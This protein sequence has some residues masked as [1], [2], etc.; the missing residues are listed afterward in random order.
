MIDDRGG[1]AGR[2]VPVFVV[3]FAISAM[4]FGGLLFAERDHLPDV[5]VTAPAS[6][7]RLSGTAQVAASY[8]VD[9]GQLHS[10]A[11]FAGGAEVES[12]S[13][14]RRS[15]TYTFSLDTTD[16]PNGSLDLRVEACGADDHSGH[17]SS[18]SVT[19]T[20]DNTP[21]ACEDDTDCD[22]NDEWTADRCVSP[23]TAA[24]SCTHKRAECMSD[25]DC[26]DNNALTLDACDATDA[27]DVKCVHT[28]IACN[29][30]SDCN[31]NDSRTLDTCIGGGTDAAECEHTSVECFSDGECD[32]KN[33]LTTDVCMSAGTAA[34]ACEHTECVVA[35]G[36]VSDC[37]DGNDLTLDTCNNPGACNASCGHI[38]VAC[39]TPA[40][41]DDGNDLT[42]DACAGAGTAAAACMHTAI[43]CNTSEDCA[44]LDEKTVDACVNGGTTSAACTHTMVVCNSAADCD[45]ED[46][47]TT[48][49][50]ANAGTAAA[51]CRHAACAVACHEDTDCDDGDAATEDVCVDNGTCNSECEHHETVCAKAADC[52]DGDDTT[53]D[54]CKNPGTPDAICEHAACIIACSAD[55]DCDDDNSITTDICEAEGTCKAA[56]S[57]SACSVECEDD[58]DCDDGDTGTVDTCLNPGTCGAICQNAITQEAELFIEIIDPA[59]GTLTNNGSMYITGM[60]ASGATVKVNG[61]DAAADDSGMFSAPVTLEEGKNAITAVAALGGRTERTAI[62]VTLDTGAPVLLTTE[63]RADSNFSVAPRVI[64]AR[65]E[66]NSGGAGL[67]V[68]SIEASVNGDTI[69]ARSPGTGSFEFPAEFEPG[70]NVIV[71]TAEDNAGNAMPP[72]TMI[73]T[74]NPPAAVDDSTL[75]MQ[76]EV[77]TVATQSEAP[78]LAAA[79]PGRW[80]EIVADQQPNA[81]EELTSEET[82]MTELLGSVL[83]SYIPPSVQIVTPGAGALA[84]GSFGV[85]VR[86]ISSNVRIGRLT[87][88]IDGAA[89]ASLELDTPSRIGG[90]TI[91]LDTLLLADG[92]HS[93]RVAAETLAYPDIPAKTGR[94]LSVGILVDNKPPE[95]EILSVDSD[96]ETDEEGVVLTA[97]FADAGAGIDTESTFVSID[98]GEPLPAEV[99][100]AAGK[101]R[102][103]RTPLSEGPH[104]FEVCA[105]DRA[106]HPCSRV[107]TTYLCRRH[108]HCKKNCPPPEPDICRSALIAQ[109][110]AV[111]DAINALDESEF[112]PNPHF[113]GELNRKKLV[114]P[115]QDALDRLKGIDFRKKDW[116]KDREGG[117]LMKVTRDI[118]EA[119]QHSDGW[120]GGRKMD[121][122]LIG[123]AGQAVVYPLLTEALAHA[124]RGG[125]CELALA[126]ESLELKKGESAQF[127]VTGTFADDT[128]L[129]LT[130]VATYTLSNAAVGSISATGVFTGL[131]SGTSTLKADKFLI[132]SNEALITVMGKPKILSI[133]PDTGPVETYVTITGSNFDPVAANNIVKFNG[134]QAEVVSAS[135]TTELVAIVPIPQPGSALVTKASGGRVYAT[136]GATTGPVTVEVSG[137]VSEEAPVF[138]VNPTP[139]IPY[140]VIPA[141]ALSADTTIT[142]KPVLH[143]DLPAAIPD[144]YIDLASIDFEP[145]GLTFSKTAYIFAGLKTSQTPFKNIPVLF[146]DDTQNPPA[147]SFSNIGLTAR[148][149]ADGKSAYAGITHF[150][151]YIWAV[152]FGTLWIDGYSSTSADYGQTISIYGGGFSGLTSPMIRFGGDPDTSLPLGT[153]P[154]GGIN[155]PSFTLSSDGLFTN[156]VVPIDANKDYPNPAYPPDF[157]GIGIISVFVYDS[158]GNMTNDDKPLQINPPVCSLITPRQVQVG[159]TISIG[160]RNFSQ[161]NGNNT[162]NFSGASTSTLSANL[163]N[164]LQLQVP[165]GATSGDVTITTY[166]A[167][168][169][170]NSPAC[171]VKI[172]PDKL[173]Y[174]PDPGADNAKILNTT[175]NTLDSASPATTGTDPVSGE[176]TA[177][178]A[179]V[180][181][182]NSASNNVSL[183]NA[184]TKA[185]A[186]NIAVGTYPADISVA[187]LFAPVGGTEGSYAYATNRASDTVS[188]INVASGTVTTT[189]NV[190]TADPFTTCDGPTGID[191]VPS[192][193]L[194]YVTCANSNNVITINTNSN[195]VTGNPIFVGVEPQ[196]I[197]ITPDGRYAFVANKF[198]DSVSVINIAT[199]NVLKTLAVGDKPRRITVLPDSTKAYVS[200]QGGNTVSVISIP[201]TG[202]S[203]ATSTISGFLSPDGLDVTPNGKK[204]YVTNAGGGTVSVIDTTSDSVATTLSGMGTTPSDITIAPYTLFTRPNITGVSTA[205][206][207]VT[208]TGT[209]FDPVWWRNTVMFNGTSPVVSAPATVTTATAGNL[210]VTLPSGA[211]SGTITVTIDNQVSNSFAYTVASPAPAI[212]SYSPAAAIPGQT[213]TITGAN[214]STTC[215][216]NVVTFGTITQAASTCSSTQLTVTVPAGVTCGTYNMFVTVGALNSNT[217]TFTSGYVLG[218]KEF[219]PDDG[220]TVLYPTWSHD[221]T[222][223]AF[224]AMK[225]NGGGTCGATN[226]CDGW[227]VYV[228]DSFASGT[229]TWGPARVITNDA[230]KVRQISGLSWNSDD[231]LVGISL[232]EAPVSNFRLYY[233][234]ADGATQDLTQAELITAG[235][236]MSSGSSSLWI[237][238]AD[239]SDS[240]CIEP[241]NRN[242][243]LAEAYDYSHGA[244]TPMEIY[245]YYDDGS[246]PNC[247]DSNGVYHEELCYV[248]KVVDLWTLPSDRNDH[249]FYPKWS[250][251]CN[252]IMVMNWAD[253]W[254]NPGF[255]IVEINVDGTGLNYGVRSNFFSAY[256]ETEL[257]NNFIYPCT[258]GCSSGQAW[259]GYWMN[260]GNSVTTSLDSTNTMWFPCISMYTD[261]VGQCFSV[262][263]MNLYMFDATSP[264]PT[265]PAGTPVK[266]DAY[267]EYVLGNCIDYTDTTNHYAKCPLGDMSNP[268][269]FV[270][271]SLGPKTDGALRFLYNWNPGPPVCPIIE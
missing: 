201:T 105:P 161:I 18:D 59:D 222:K 53:L 13:P 245:A 72:K 250:P 92:R 25:T 270:Y 269:V 252:K 179:W 167:T 257:D 107:W 103:A 69:S 50:C 207:T 153:I 210:V 160:G 84:Q 37:D 129:D 115:L 63:P 180:L 223:V 140:V 110:I 23:G 200:N 135:G 268:Y 45:D 131:E 233:V 122:F 85:E 73:V 266:T 26:N 120:Y 234:E 159:D 113:N 3:L 157:N 98:D 76:P 238:S 175:T 194:A 239:M 156:V 14:G 74:Y 32:D 199:N 141:A 102:F 33:A 101:I 258:G 148:V 49:S 7:A 55:S 123:Q 64:T 108:K 15:G 147:E 12:V 251:D 9:S 169:T 189:I 229:L 165:S 2:F 206:T 125:L 240:N 40:D 259:S 38:T 79:I 237:H 190:A 246:H 44:D 158:G 114:R 235:Y 20:I 216:N 227:N 116:H 136:A 256:T 118:E 182:A 139:F 61:A 152:A 213:I 193:K 16:Y 178:G 254:D 132:E 82:A 51:E 134:M 198:D 267:H 24:A 208:I 271:T 214:F 54:S 261:V 22:D 224:I 192:G 241:M 226:T 78:D 93:L 68:S 89:A 247:I 126:P 21:A 174:I 170:V 195:A 232:N 142:V 128:T 204:V 138:T 230:M 10:L 97:R 121:D 112:R 36:S 163:V 1:V 34:A 243:L 42:L 205:G 218:R 212:Y 225:A 17:C 111:I 67:D 56:C 172:E 202:T 60:T 28:A 11:L 106:G 65:I 4:V 95:V 80:G 86:Y 173:A 211:V 203:F 130:S 164:A 77:E 109:L 220:A 264:G 150:S 188:V 244:G 71:F 58:A 186:S 242:V 137:E 144:N 117:I 183:I 8:S 181:I 219:V 87:V 209:N 231:T 221:G 215:A 39:G 162:V 104:K 29:Y 263:D 35:C 260:D 265:P 19:V 6:G 96:A 228:I 236:R 88:E 47:T 31:D 133:S 66:D 177:D 70:M 43:A 176:F 191:V 81:P 185:F 30:A 255:S 145:D 166:F 46:A 217:V 262:G 149:L 119:I 75:D 168:S 187:P 248:K 90:A 27:D 41:C 151:H 197:T 52:D 83:P 48:D 171:A 57:H 94:S 127:T 154:T 155:S 100:A 91:P 143:K 5:D 146:F 124:R 253:G 62:N 196:Y 184:T 249:L 99:D